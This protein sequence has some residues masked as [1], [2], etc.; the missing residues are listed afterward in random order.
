M[1]PWAVDLWAGS[2]GTGPGTGR[3]SRGRP[4]RDAPWRPGN[5][6]TGT[7]GSLVGVGVGSGDYRQWQAGGAG[8]T[9]GVQRQRRA[10]S[11][12]ASTR[13]QHRNG[14][15]SAPGWPRATTA[16]AARSTGVGSGAGSGTGRLV[17]AGGLGQQQRWLWSAPARAGNNT[18]NGGLVGASA[19][20]DP[21]AA[22]AGSSARRRP[23]ATTAARAGWSVPAA[24]ATTPAPGQWAP[25]R[26]RQNTARRLGRC[27]RGFGR[28]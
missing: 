5:P 4:R 20:R 3:T 8:V 22:M 16:R 11:V 1:G 2:P 23:V 28:Q 24:S 19:A 17:R 15:S 9:S 21:I 14:G 7:G 18:G 6:G 10:W 25:A 12:Q 27:Q 13:R 26:G